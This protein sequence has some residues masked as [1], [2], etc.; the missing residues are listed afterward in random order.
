LKKL[1]IYLGKISL[2]LEE[3]NE[4]E[5]NWGAE[6]NIRRNYGHG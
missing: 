4:K 3:E 1:R 5:W 6:K 2:D